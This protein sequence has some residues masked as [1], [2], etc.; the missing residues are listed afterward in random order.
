MAEFEQDDISV[1]WL[2]LGRDGN[3]VGDVY[4]DFK[5]GCFTSSDEDKFNLNNIVCIQQPKHVDSLDMSM[6]WR[7]L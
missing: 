5:C 1:I 3:A 7:K 4:V 6:W 2:P